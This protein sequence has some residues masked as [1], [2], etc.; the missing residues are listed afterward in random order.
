MKRAIFT[1]IAIAVL[2]LTTR[3]T[4]N[5]L[6]VVQP[7]ET[8]GEASPGQISFTASM[9]GPGGGSSTTSPGETRIAIAETADA[10]KLTWEEG[11]KIDL[12]FEQYIPG[13]PQIP[14]VVVTVKGVAVT[15]DPQNP[16]HGTF[17]VNVPEGIDGSRHFNLHGIYGGKGFKEN[18]TEWDS[19]MTASQMAPVTLEE[20]RRDMCLR[21]VQPGVTADNAGGDVV[22][23]HEGFFFR[24]ELANVSTNDSFTV[25]GSLKVILE[26]FMPATNFNPWVKVIGYG[27][28]GTFNYH[29][30]EFEPFIGQE[31]FE[32]AKGATKTLWQWC[33][34]ADNP[35]GEERQR[36]AL[37]L[38]MHSPNNPQDIIS[39][40]T[41][42]VGG[43]LEAG[44]TYAIAAQLN[45]VDAV[46]HMAWELKFTNP[47][48][49]TPFLPVTFAAQPAEGGTVKAATP[50][51]EVVSGNEVGYRQQVTFTATPAPGY[52]FKGWR[53][54]DVEAGDDNPSLTLTP[55]DPT[56]VEAL[57]AQARITFT[58][59]KQVG[60]EIEVWLNA[61][62]A[63]RAHIWIDL[64]NNGTKDSGEAVVKFE[65]VQSYTLAAQTVTVYGKVTEINIPNNDITELDL[66]QNPGLERLGCII[67]RLFH[68]DL[69]QN[70][71]LKGL[72]CMGNYIECLDL[73]QNPKLEFL[74]CE[75]NHLAEL[76]LSGCTELTRLD[77]FGNELTSLDVSSCTKLTR[78]DCSNNRLTSLDVSDCAEL[79]NLKCGYNPLG[80]LDVRHNLKL[81]QLSVSRTYLTGLDVSQN[82]K[83][84]ELT[85]S[86]TYLTGLDV[87]QNRVLSWLNCSDC[88][89]NS[90]AI[91]RIINDLPD[92][93]ESYF[94]GH[95]KFEGNPSIPLQSDVE[96]G[97]A[98][99]WEI[100]PGYV[101]VEGIEW[102]Q[103]Y[104]ITLKAGMTK[105]LLVKVLPED[106]TNKK[107]IWTSYDD[108][109]VRVNDNG[110][111][112]AMRPGTTTVTARTKCG[113]HKTYCTITVVE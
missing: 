106:A 46:T 107:V 31:G 21:F 50:Q 108:Q 54:N 71:A 88:K 84:T 86:D 55:E 111:A 83:L 43:K 32:I 34:P 81:K 22:F 112:V 15:P 72:F 37:Q 92:R 77:C 91:T 19:P 102:L 7:S 93:K 60:E 9:P 69:S 67:N 98:K 79:T 16:R 95:A 10:L 47:S 6:S 82:L 4:D 59:D 97:F 33:M 66:S 51:G 94:E 57:F 62:E 5:D 63:E 20:L 100:T 90:E 12:A 89:F 53:V 65:E 45:Y 78:L 74:Y 104:E 99:N 3:C 42:P 109:V 18:S 105:E 61:D 49:I 28:G 29:R 96:I 56:N 80:R 24:L 52:T 48:A 2:L 101:P 64:N 113:N 17:N 14:A 87:S 76:K 25:G 44:K 58:T 103:G 35:D 68:L 36:P 38:R 8:A 23:K 41:L 85:V 26:E 75:A 39:K 13:L 110:L 30:V 1:A 11:D 73:S 27:N 70:P 40:N